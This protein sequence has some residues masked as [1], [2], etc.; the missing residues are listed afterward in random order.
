MEKEREKKQYKKKVF[1]R[2]KEKRNNAR[3]RSFYG[4]RKRKEAIQ[5]KEVFM[6]KERK[7]KQD[8]KKMFLWNKKKKNNTRRRKRR[9]FC[10]EWNRD[11]KVGNLKRRWRKLVSDRADLIVLYLLKYLWAVHSGGLILVRATERKTYLNQKKIYFVLP[12]FTLIIK[13]F[14][15]EMIQFTNL[16]ILLNNNMSSVFQFWTRF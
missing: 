4:E 16:A 9:T 7:K 11:R 2:K 13:D 14:A 8:K 5:E 10:E 15:Q 1:L 12:K 6:E 3:K